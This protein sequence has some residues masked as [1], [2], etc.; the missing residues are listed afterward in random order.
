MMA[1]AFLPSFLLPS[2][3]SFEAGLIISHEDAEKRDPPAPLKSPGRD[4]SLL[5]LLCV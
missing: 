5:Q 1:F 4:P 2:P 3:R